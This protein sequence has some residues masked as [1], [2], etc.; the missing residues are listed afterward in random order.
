MTK[1]KFSRP[2]E[3]GEHLFALAQWAQ[4]QD[5]NTEDLLRQ[6]SRRHE[7]EWRKLERDSPP[8]GG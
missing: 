5:W 1:P 8:G 7:R 2:E 6:A 4:E 3:L